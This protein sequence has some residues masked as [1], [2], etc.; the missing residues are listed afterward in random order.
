MGESILVAD[1]E[2]IERKVLEK[3]IKRMFPEEN[4][5]A[6]ANG[7]EVLSLYAQYHPI[8]LVLDIR[9]PGVD[10]LEAARQIREEDPSC[11]IIF[12]TAFDEFS[13]ARKAISVRAMDYLLK[14]CEDG[15]LEASVSEGIRAA[16]ETARIIRSAGLRD[17]QGRS[18]RSVASLDKERDAG[19]Q[20]EPQLSRGNGASDEKEAGEVPGG[21]QKEMLSCI[22]ENFMKELS[23]Q[24]MA[25]RFGYN[26]AYFC[27]IFKQLFGKSFVTYLTDFRIGKAKELMEQSDD[28]VK[29]I[30]R[31]VGYED[32]NYFA[33]VFRRVTGMSP[34]AY[35]ERGSGEG[36]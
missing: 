10:G 31:A 28:S 9:M 27:R 13:Y 25:S 19:G 4:V 18:D 15:E 24:D 14:P 6:A 1:D 17:G 12:L 8:V 2:F 21:E 34:S 3:K 33:K 23:V 20:M 32:S 16:K 30:A 11:S 29:D 22:E 7:R 5:L 36:G 26:D 35:R